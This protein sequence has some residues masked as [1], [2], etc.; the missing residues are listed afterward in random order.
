MGPVNESCLTLYIFIFRKVDP[1]GKRTWGIITKVDELDPLD[2]GMG[3]LGK[4]LDNKTNPLK[5]GYLAVVSRSQDV[6]TFQEN[7]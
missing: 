4:V 3:E 7:A 1:Y 6:R 2:I 5:M